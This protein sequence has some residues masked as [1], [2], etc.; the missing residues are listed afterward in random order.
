MFIRFL[1]P[2]ARILRSYGGDP[3]DEGDQV[4]DLVI[5]V[6]FVVRRHCT[7]LDAVFDDPESRRSS[8]RQNLTDRALQ[9]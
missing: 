7:H 1:F 6:D 3:L 9:D 4:P 2:T 8:D 5:I